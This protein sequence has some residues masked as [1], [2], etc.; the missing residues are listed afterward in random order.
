MAIKATLTM[1]GPRGAPPA[2]QAPMVVGPIFAAPHLGPFSENEEFAWAGYEWMRAYSRDYY[3]SKQE[4][5]EARWEG[6]K[7]WWRQIRSYVAGM[8]EE[9]AKE[10]VA[11]IAANVRPAWFADV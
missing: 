7:D 2:H 11:G 5:G 3:P 9:E 1:T 10:A 8:T 6:F 4:I